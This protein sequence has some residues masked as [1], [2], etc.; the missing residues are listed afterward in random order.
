MDLD[1]DKPTSLLNSIYR[2]IPKRLVKSYRLK[3]NWKYKIMKI[4]VQ[5]QGE[6]GRVK[7]CEN[8]QFISEKTMGLYHF[9]V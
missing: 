2:L 1:I 9:G 5:I 3:T 4:G 6:D 8:K 7:I